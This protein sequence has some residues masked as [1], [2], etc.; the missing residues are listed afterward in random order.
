MAKKRFDKYV[1]QRSNC[2]SCFTKQITTVE[3][4]TP[5]RC[6]IDDTLNSLTVF[7]Q[8]LIGLVEDDSDLVVLT[9]Q[10]FD[11]S[12]ELVADVQLVRVEQK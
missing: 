10:P 3:F 5:P 11:H 12:L 2:P 4:S 9:L 8:H 6:K 1:K 7:L